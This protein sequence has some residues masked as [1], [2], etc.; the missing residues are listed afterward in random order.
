MRRVV[1]IVTAL[2][3]LAAAV[4]AYAASSGFN[5]YTASVSVSPNKASSPVAF[6]ETYTASGTN[7]NRTAPLRDIKTKVYGIVTNGKSFPTCSEAKIAQA[8]SDAGCP[9]VSTL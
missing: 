3:V 2:A 9:K 6:T 8:K 1:V 5:S 7:G 4:S